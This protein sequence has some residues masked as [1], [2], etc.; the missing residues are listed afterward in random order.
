MLEHVLVLLLQ[1]VEKIMKDKTLRKNIILFLFLLLICL[2]TLSFVSAHP[3]HGSEY[4][5]EIT[6]EDVSHSQPSK[7]VSTSDSSQSSH[8]STDSSS[9]S[10]SS[11]GS[12]SPSSKGDSKSS[13]SYKSSAKDGDYSS[14]QTIQGDLSNSNNKTTNDNNNFSK[15]IEDNS[16]DIIKNKANN[17]DNILKYIFIAVCS[18]LFGL[19]VVYVVVRYIL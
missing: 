17:E 13:S 4:V 3:G 18:F 12:K 2:I 14:K 8:S 16:S 19:I 5:E 7:E 11:K 9:N 15:D 6:S 1:E 10:H